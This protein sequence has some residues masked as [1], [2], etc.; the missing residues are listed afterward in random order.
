[1]QLMHTWRI[2]AIALASTLLAACASE[3]QR[4]ENKA[5]DQQLDTPVSVKVTSPPFDEA[6]AKAA[7]AKGNSTVKG[8]V[9]HKIMNG[10]KQAGRDAPILS[11]A[12][13]SP[14]PNVTVFL[15]PATEH[16]KELIRLENE[17]RS[18]RAW[19]KVQLKNFVG[20]PRVP[21]YVLTAK[22]D[23]NGLFEFTEMRPGNYLIYV[24]NMLV[25]SSGQETIPVGSSYQTA[26]YVVSRHGATEI[27]RLV[28]HTEEH[29]F[30]VNTEISFNEIINVPSNNTV[31]KIEARM[32]PV[33]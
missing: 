20:D 16:V 27:P 3:M 26:G 5:Q 22:T 6:Y 12:K 21:K 18:E 1:M 29:H 33:R 8:V 15:Y 28:V 14:I 4:A 2:M 30:K 32:R 24:D 17:N 25:T 31:V 13:G 9:F 7:L 23:A 19:R 11:F 10:G